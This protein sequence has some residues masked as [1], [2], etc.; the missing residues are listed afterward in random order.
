MRNAVRVFL[1]T[2]VGMFFGAF[3]F[4]QDAAIVPPTNEEISAWLALIGGM[5]GAGTM[6]IIVAV[7]QGA[8][9]LVRSSLTDSLGK[10]KLLL[11]AALT[12]IGV[13]VTEYVAHNG[14]MGQILLKGT[15]LAALQVL[16][17][18]AYKQFKPAA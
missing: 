15:F 11:V 8:T 12:F 7:V 3:A 2:L 18:Q 17:N 9:L 16:L 13:T 4:A 14:D 6:A 5:K 10:Y 1:I